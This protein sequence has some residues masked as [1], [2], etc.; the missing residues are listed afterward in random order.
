M[1]RDHQYVKEARRARHIGEIPENFP[2]GARI[3]DGRTPYVEGRQHVLPGANHLLAFG[4]GNLVRCA[5]S[6]SL[7]LCPC[8]PSLVIHWS[9]AN[10]QVSPNWA[11]T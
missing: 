7:R 5:I 10:R 6:L 2:E 4:V 9:F 8:R 11:T 1:V 3:D